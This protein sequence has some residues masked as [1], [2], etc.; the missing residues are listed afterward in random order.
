MTN[1]EKQQFIDLANSLGYSY[2][3]VD[4]SLGGGFISGAIA[5]GEVTITDSVVLTLSKKIV[6]DV[7]SGTANSQ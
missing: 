7:A 1:V 3:L 4:Q 5:S 2:S 6:I